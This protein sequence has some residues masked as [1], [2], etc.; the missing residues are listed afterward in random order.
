MDFVPEAVRILEVYNEIPLK[1]TGVLLGILGHSANDPGLT[2]D[3]R[4][5]NR[6]GIR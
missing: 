5:T 1:S 3:N 6:V 4:V 2:L